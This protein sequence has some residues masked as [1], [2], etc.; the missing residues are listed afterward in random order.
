MLGPIMALLQLQ[1]VP[2]TGRARRS[3][4]DSSNN[5]NYFQVISEG[6]GHAGSS[7][8]V[9]SGILYTWYMAEQDGMYWHVLLCTALYRGLH[10]TRWYKPGPATSE[11]VHASG[12]TRQYKQRYYM[13]GTWPGTRSRRYMAA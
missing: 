2:V 7:V 12:G 3:L 4:A 10:G 9:T 5:L 1:T 13:V 8:T 6:P 11:V